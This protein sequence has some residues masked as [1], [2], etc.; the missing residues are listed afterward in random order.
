MLDDF[1]L[2]QLVMEPTHYNH[3]LDLL[4]TSHPSIISDI[5][6]IPGMSDHEATIGKKRPITAKR[7][8]YLYY[9]A[10]LDEVKTTSQSFH[11]I[12]FSGD[13]YKQS[14]EEN[15]ILLKQCILDTIDDLVRICA[16]ASVAFIVH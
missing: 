11:N 6:I 13:P 9:K 8:V 12:F 1:N 16:W 14:V 2:S 5:S 4:L 10:N 15:W 7:K 3:V